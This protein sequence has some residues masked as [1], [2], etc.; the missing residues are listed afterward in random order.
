MAFVTRRGFCTWRLNEA[1][2]CGILGRIF[3]TGT[4]YGRTIRVHQCEV[5]PEQQIV[6]GYS[7]G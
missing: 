6:H 1:A 5:I 3:S 4:D 2:G 7:S